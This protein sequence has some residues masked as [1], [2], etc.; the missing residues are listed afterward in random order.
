MYVFIII[1]IKMLVDRMEPNGW[2]FDER[3]FMDGS[4][5]DGSR[6]PQHSRAPVSSMAMVDDNAVLQEL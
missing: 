4:L 3:K 6:R 5:M 1:I 2:K